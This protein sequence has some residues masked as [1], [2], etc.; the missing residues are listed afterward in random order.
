MVET[1]LNETELGKLILAACFVTDFGTVLALGVL[2]ASFNLWMLLFLVI[3]V[4]VLWKLQP[5]TRWL[6]GKWGGRVSE[7][8]VKFLFVLLF[9]LGGLATTAQS[10]AVLPAY[11]VGLIIAGVFVRN[12]V[13]V[14]RIRSIAFAL[15]TPFFFIKAGML[16]SLP[17]VVTGALLIV[18]LLAVKVGT[19]FL[20]VWPLT[21]LFKMTPREGNYITLLMSTG[22]TFGSISALYGLTHGIINQAQYTI[23][24]TVVIGSALL[25]TF[26]AQTW[27]LPKRSTSLSPEAQGEVETLMEEDAVLEGG[28]E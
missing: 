9:L 27:F 21:R 25:P 23:L 24:V 26:I 28:K 12:K 4:V 15:L 5:I 2:F 18:V 14:Y 11:L 10:E 16:I 3:L 6:I 13:L 1:G 20:G 8:E 17:A 22:L 19:K 7:V